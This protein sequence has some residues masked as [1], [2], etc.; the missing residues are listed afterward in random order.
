MTPSLREL[1][2]EALRSGAFNGRTVED[3]FKATDAVLAVLR[4]NPGVVLSELG[5]EQVCSLCHEPR[6]ECHNFA[7]FEPVFRFPSAVTEDEQ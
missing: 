4:A 1:L 5:A 7:D 6:S 3:R 2:A